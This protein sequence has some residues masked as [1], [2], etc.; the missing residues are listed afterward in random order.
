MNE[1]QLIAGCKAREQESQKSLYE[2]YARKIYG[3]CLR[4]TANAEA[5]QDLLH[6]GFIKVF[7]SIDSYSGKG[8]FEGWLKRVFINLALEQIRKDKSVF[9]TSEDI[10]ELPDIVD[11]STEEKANITE[12]ELLSMIQGLP[13]GYRTVFNLYA[14]ENLSH[15]E[16]AE[17]LGINEATSRSQY[18]RARQILQNK[19]ND[20][21]KNN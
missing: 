14:I 12:K 10:Q 19:V 2:Q 7:N 17:M 4:Y 18:N 9:S 8:S 15:K 16:I 11:E 13:K 3:I 1:V 6:D 21:L 20:Y 5:A